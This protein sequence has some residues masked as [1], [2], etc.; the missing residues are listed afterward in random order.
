LGL[1]IWRHMR[2]HMKRLKKMEDQYWTFMSY[3]AKLSADY[4]NMLPLTIT[5][6]TNQPT[7]SNITVLTY[8]GSTLPQSSLEMFIDKFVHLIN[9]H[10]C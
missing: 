7:T 1:D 9:E 2:R 8:T 3:F 10:Y 5:P 4:K 6:N